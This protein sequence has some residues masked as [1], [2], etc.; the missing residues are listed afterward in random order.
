MKN[1][2]LFGLK[3]A[4]LVL[5]SILASCIHKNS[6]VIKGTIT[7]AK[8]TY[9][10]LLDFD[11]VS[12]H[13]VDST[14]IKKDGSFKFKGK[15]DEIKF[16]QL[17]LAHDNYML[18][19]V[20]P[21]QRITVKASADA[22][23]SNYTVEGSEGSVQ[24]KTLTDKLNSTRFKIESL[25]SVYRKKNGTAGFDTTYKRINDQYVTTVKEQRKFSIQFIIDHLRSMPSIVAL[26]QQLDDSTL[27]LNENRDLQYVK[28][29]SDTLMKY[30]PNSKLV[31]TLYNDRIRLLSA[32]NNLK[33][34]AMSKS[35][36]TV[37]FP[38]IELPGTNKDIIRLSKVK[39]KCILL[40]FWSDSN[41]DCFY[42][43][44]SYKELYKKYHSKGF[45]IYNVALLENYADWL[46]LIKQN[47]IP[48]INVI[49]LRGGNS[50]FAK[51][52]NLNKLPSNFIIGPNSDILVR[53]I[54]G[55]NLESKIKN[56]LGQK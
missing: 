18:L 38:E 1:K 4:L 5:I 49:D 54:F 37:S 35:S 51:L 29:V 16:Y 34:S 19:Q 22:L 28:L 31:K 24:I 47:E 30:Y 33:L 17:W 32:F 52:Y 44:N 21:G 36:K 43:L 41:E 12:N 6:Y 13:L 56:I 50:Y 23:S 3:L 45:E 27:V 20:E 15:I 53:D 55:E 9:V 39:G 48:G 26:Y 40:N 14:E 8:S 25:I 10:Y 2:T 46:K 42:A 7:N 11:L